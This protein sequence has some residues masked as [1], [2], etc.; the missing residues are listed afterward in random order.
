MLTAIVAGGLAGL[1]LLAFLIPR[2]G[3][4]AAIL[5]I[6]AN[7]VFTAWATLTMNGGH[8]WNLHRW[9]Y[10]WHELTIGAV[11]NS[12]MFLVGFLASVVLPADRVAGPTLWDW[13]AISRRAKHEKILGDSN[14]SIA[15]SS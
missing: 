2:A 1:F 12:L 9:N 11:G 8:T 3:R 6:V 10:P 13:L 4:G 5:A 7:L 14:E 15:Q